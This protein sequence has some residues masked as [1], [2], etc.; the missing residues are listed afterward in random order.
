MG[1]DRS[2]RRPVVAVIRQRT[3]KFPD[4]PWSRYIVRKALAMAIAIQRYLPTEWQ[5]PS[6]TQDMVAVLETLNCPPKIYQDERAMAAETVS[7]IEDRFGP[8]EIDQE[9]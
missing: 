3:R 1:V 2:Y 5:E 7:H 4:P 8:L 9:D 6:D